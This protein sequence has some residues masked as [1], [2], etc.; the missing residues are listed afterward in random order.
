MGRRY[1][2]VVFDMDGTLTQIRSS[3]SYIHSVLGV[4]NEASYKA[5]VNM[6]IDEPEFM[7]RD[8]ALW[9]SVRPNIT[10]NDIARM[11]RDMPLTEGIQETVTCLEYN[12]IR[13]VICSGGIDMAAR[14]IVREFGFDDY[15]ADSLGTNPD[16][17]LTGEGI[18]NIDLM[19]KGIWVRKFIEKFGTTKDRTVSIGNSFTDIKMFENSG[20]SIAFNPSD[21][22]TEKAATHIV[23]SK[24]ISDVLGPILEIQDGE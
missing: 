11:F 15:I 12:D 13:C 14:M 1:D 6:E 5:F 2:L 22:F 18:M 24:N 17:T 21:E 3:W 20:M 10:V 7:R 23:R 8:I 16:G 19:D 4:N 9:K